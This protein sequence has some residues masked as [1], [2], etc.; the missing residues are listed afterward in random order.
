MAD[1]FLF[2]IAESV[3]E[4]LGSLALQ[5]FYLAWG[6]GSELEK[7]KDNL[8][9]IKAMLLIAKQQRSQNP[10]IE[11]WSE[12]L[13][14]GLYDAEDVVDEFE[15]E[16]LR[17]QVVKSGNTTRKMLLMSL[18]A[19][20]LEI[21]SLK[22]R[23]NIIETLLQSVNAENVSII[24]IVGI[25]GIGKTTLAKLVYGDQRIATHFELKL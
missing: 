5:E 4:K 3:L 1:S 19:N 22:H 23:D 20:K 9:V 24:P 2:S 12:I 8:K 6:L 7:I 18:G 25:G 17:R 14:E 15:C 11:V 13:K 10:R 21:T 16:A